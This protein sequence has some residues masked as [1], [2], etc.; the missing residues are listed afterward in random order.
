M[1]EIEFLKQV[2][3][4]Y[5]PSGEEKKLADFL[6]SRMKQ[7][8]FKSWIDEAGNVIGEIGSGRPILLFLPH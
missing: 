4:I 8:G 1:D 6:C 5:S 2:L 7:L 3:K